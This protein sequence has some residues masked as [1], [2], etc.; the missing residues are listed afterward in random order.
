MHRSCVSNLHLARTK[1]ED[2]QM[3]TQPFKLNP[4]YLELCV[5]IKALLERMQP[6]VFKNALLW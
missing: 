2:E 6:H 4:N 1:E 3:I 5:I